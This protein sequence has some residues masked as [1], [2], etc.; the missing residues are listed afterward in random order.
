MSM[1]SAGTL[2]PR[3]EELKIQHAKRGRRTAMALEIRFVMPIPKRIA[4][5]HGSRPRRPPRVWQMLLG[6]RENVCKK[7]ALLQSQRMRPRR[8]PVPQN[9]SNLNEIIVHI[10][11]AALTSR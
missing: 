3:M 11:Q 5:P 1:L 7:H 9:R 10:E 6:V 8:L 2:K 4:A